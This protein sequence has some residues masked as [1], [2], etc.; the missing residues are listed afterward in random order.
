MGYFLALGFFSIPWGAIIRLLP[1]KPF[2]SLFKAIRLV[3]KEEILPVVKPD[4]EG[5]GGAGSRQSQYILQYPWSP[6]LP[7]DDQLR[8]YACSRR[9]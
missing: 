2:E 7:Q 6:R 3:R 5:W 8:M 4:R 1:T 9:F